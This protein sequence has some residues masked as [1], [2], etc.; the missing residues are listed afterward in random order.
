MQNKAY[1]FLGLYSAYFLGGLKEI[2]QFPGY[3]GGKTEK[4]K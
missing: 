3:F 2:L 4:Q 1:P